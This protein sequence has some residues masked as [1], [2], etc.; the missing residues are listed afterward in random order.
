MS[1]PHVIF[2][3][4]PGT[5]KSSMLN[6]I[7]G[8]AEFRSGYSVGR[9]MTALLQKV[10]HNNT[11]YADTPGLADI[12]RKEQAAAEIKQ[13]L[14][15]AR[16][17]T[18]IFVVTLE[19]GRVR[20]SDLLTIQVILK[21][22]VNTVTKNRFGI[23]INKVS[24][25]AVK[26]INPENET[27]ILRAFQ[28]ENENYQ[29]SF[30]YYNRKDDALEDLDDVVATPN[31]GLE[32]FI[33]SITPVELESE[34]VRDI[35]TTDY[36]AQVASIGLELARVQES[37]REQIAGYEVQFNEL[38]EQAAQELALQQEQNRVASVANAELLEKIREDFTKQTDQFKRENQQLH[39]ESVRGAEA[40]SNDLANAMAL[41]NA[42]HENRE[43]VAEAR[44][45]KADMQRIIHDMQIEALK[46]RGEDRLNSEAQIAALNSQM[47]NKE[48]KKGGACV[49]A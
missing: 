19:A 23:V 28:Q 26:H 27:L 18:L 39:N 45:D 31:P 7:V 29:T 14:L 6:S 17:L 42:Q 38:K 1:Y 46:Q 2:A 40:R 4:N 43:M 49:V 35:D 8:R 30:I 10:L 21:S 36:A 22:M 16:K 47:K 41:M 33:G 44:R 24:A 34:N 12:E 15:E 5:G 20:P 9:G 13:I 11:I 48:D 25:N 32:A 3:G 37:T